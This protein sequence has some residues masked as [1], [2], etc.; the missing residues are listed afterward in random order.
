MM[1]ALATIQTMYPSVG[2]VLTLPTLPDGLVDTGKAVV[3][4]AK[5][6][7]VTFATNL[8]VRPT[9]IPLPFGIWR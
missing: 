3:K 1:P 7:G 2:I 8:M 5:D 9:M 6:N 4:L